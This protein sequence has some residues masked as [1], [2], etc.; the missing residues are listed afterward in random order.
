M[1]RKISFYLMIWFLTVGRPCFSQISEEK[2]SE[3]RKSSI[4]TAVDFSKLFEQKTITRDD[5]EN[6]KRQKEAGLQAQMS[7]AVAL[8]KAVDP[9]AYIL[10]PGDMLSLNVWGGV[11]IR[12]PAVVNPE[13][14]LPIPTIGEI[15]ADGKTLSEVQDIVLAKAKSVYSNSTT[16]FTL[17]ALR[18][19]R[20]HLVGA[21]KY[22]GAYVA[23]AVN[24]I[25]EI[26]E[27]GGGVS[28]WAWKKGIELRHPSG[29][30]DQFDLSLYEQSGA[31]EQN[32]FVN[33]GDIIYV[34]PIS[35]GSDVVH[36]EGDLELSG[37]YQIVPHEDLMDFLFRIRALQKNTEMAFIRIKRESGL[38]KGK[39]QMG[40]APFSN[41][42]AYCPTPLFGGDR[43]VLP[44]KYVYVKG[45]VRLPG[46][47]L[48][49]SNLCAK[50]YVGMAGILNG[51]SKI[52]AATVFHVS[53]GKTE[54]GGN[55]VVE[56]GD[57]VQLSSSWTDRAQPY[58]VLLSA[59]TSLILT[60]KVAG[61]FGK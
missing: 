59:V 58:A 15:M 46:A 45:A 32:R 6:L 30:I 35:F 53:N 23:Q 57:L 49:S 29:K 40:W 19:F 25:S 13:G 39:G 55:V 33:G 22:P 17:E 60:A 44:S 14:K 7:K 1:M 41:D 26:I 36:V 56:P 31:L 52:K 34:P 2:T 51:A 47:Y 9:S 38:N 4:P 18:S 28:D 61:L 3:G 5:F 54:N 10:G 16:S 8:E 27:E 37:T 20:I 48:Y 50:D 11:E 21:V 24:R 12:Y 42:S 43:I